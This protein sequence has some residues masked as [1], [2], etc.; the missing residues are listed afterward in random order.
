MLKLNEMTSEHPF[1]MFMQGCTSCN[2]KFVATGYRYT[3]F[4]FFL[5]IP[6]PTVQL[7]LHG[8][9]NMYDMCQ[10]HIKSWWGGI[11]FIW[12]KTDIRISAVPPTVYSLQ[13]SS[14]LNML[15]FHHHIVLDLNS[16]S[17]RM[18]LSNMIA[19]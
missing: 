4:L 11:V 8:P 9:Q 6:P 18:L 19:L 17:V 3:S 10:L 13:F 1:F 12:N 15:V 2:D 5:F 7:I 16:I 14:L